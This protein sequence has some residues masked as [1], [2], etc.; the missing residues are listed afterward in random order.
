M[1]DDLYVWSGIWQGMGYSAVI[2]IAALSG[3]SPELK[4]AAIC[5]GATRLQRIRH[6]DLP[7]IM[8][9]VVTLLI[10][11]C[12]GI[13]NIGFDKVFLMQNGLNLAKSE[14]IS[15]FVYKVGLEKANYSFAT[16]AGLLQS[17]VS[18]VI[19]LIANTVAKKASGI[20]LW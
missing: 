20:S 4:E 19:L 2:Y 11:A 7:S 8:P 10:F 1:F 15:T 13:V 18:F 3:V 16:A 9:T 14:V 17:V 5:D 12:S 6:V